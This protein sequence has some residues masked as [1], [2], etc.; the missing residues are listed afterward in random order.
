M[1]NHKKYYFTAIAYA[2]ND[3]STFDPTDFENTQQSPYLQGRRNIRTYTG[4]PHKSEPDATIINAQYG[5]APQITRIDGEGM[6]GNFIELTQESI[7]AI[8]A[9]GSQEQFKYQSNAGPFNVKVYDPLRLQGGTYTLKLTDS[10]MSDDELKEPIG[11]VLEGNG[12]TITNEKPVGSAYEQLIPEL[13]ISISVGQV[14]EVFSDPLVTNGFLGARIEYADAGGPEWYGAM[15]DDAFGFLSNFIKTSA[16]EPDEDKD[17]N[18]VFS[19][20]LGGAWSPFYLTT[21]TP[22]AIGGGQ[23]FFITPRPDNS[24]IN[25]QFNQGGGK[26]IRA[27]PNVDIVLTSD[28]SKWSRCVVVN[29]FSEFYADIGGIPMPNSDEDHFSLRTAQSVNKDGQ[30]DGSGTGMSWFPGYAINVESGERLNVF[31]G[32]NTLYGSD[33]L[34]TPDPSG[35]DMIWNPSTFVAVSDQPASIAEFSFGGQHHV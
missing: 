33:F 17:P 15:A 2:H 30:P 8:C 6:G 13:G 29:T 11:W 20:V 32:E 12:V 27:L 23:D 3:Y 21:A 28:K 31:F 18:K 5:D 9:S 7:E 19:N 4:I 24:F 26:R 25:T 22:F 1:V 34:P 16:G 35:N 14:G 10:D